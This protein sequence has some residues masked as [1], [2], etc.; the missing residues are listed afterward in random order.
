MPNTRTVRTI[1]MKPIVNSELIAAVVHAIDCDIYA[2]YRFYSCNHV[3]YDM[4]Y[5]T[6]RFRSHYDRRNKMHFEAYLQQQLNKIDLPDKD[7]TFLRTKMLEMY[8]A[9]DRKSVV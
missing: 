7:E 3:A 1:R 2:H 5:R 9:V 6:M 4:L 8:S